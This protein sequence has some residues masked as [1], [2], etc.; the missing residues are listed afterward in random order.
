MQAQPGEEV[1]QV[2]ET[3]QCDQ[4]QQER[5]QREQHLVGQCGSVGRHLVVEE[6]LDGAYQHAVQGQAAQVGEN[7]SVSFRRLIRG[8]HG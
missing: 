6:F 8:Y 4:E 7:H 5:E 2:Q 3:D 1:R